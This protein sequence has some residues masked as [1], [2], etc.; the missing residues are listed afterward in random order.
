MID[1]KITFPADE[2][3]YEDYEKMSVISDIMFENFCDNLTPKRHYL[4]N[5]V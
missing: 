2:L 1:F 3:L 4:L 5:K